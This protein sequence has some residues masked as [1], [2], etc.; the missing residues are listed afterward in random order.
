MIGTFDSVVYEDILKR[1]ILKNFGD[2]QG[3]REYINDSNRLIFQHDGRKPHHANNINTYF[4][5]RKIEGRILA[6]K[7]TRLKLNRVS[8]GISKE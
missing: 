3:D 6:A 4:R 5:E 7:V 2:L 8:L 1:R